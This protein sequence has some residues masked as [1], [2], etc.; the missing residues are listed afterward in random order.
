MWV[1]MRPVHCHASLSLSSGEFLNFK[2]KSLTCVQNQ[3]KTF[4]ALSQ[5]EIKFKF[6]SS[7]YLWIFPVVQRILPA[8][9]KALFLSY[10]SHK[11]DRQGRKWWV[12]KK[13]KSAWHCCIMLSLRLGKP[14]LPLL[15]LLSLMSSNFVLSRFCSRNR[16]LR[17]SS[18]SF[19]S[20]SKS[21]WFIPFSLEDWS[22]VKLI[23]FFLMVTL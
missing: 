9:F 10:N 13:R 20:A 14:V 16:I 11:E 19:C 1:R 5:L 23:P 12:K 18:W 7:I 15:P 8:W 4:T 6:F 17:R 3:F 21:L 22:E 2:N